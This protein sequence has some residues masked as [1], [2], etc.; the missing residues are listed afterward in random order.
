MAINQEFVDVI[1]QYF[2]V[3]YIKKTQSLVKRGKTHKE[4]LDIHNEIKII[5][6]NDSTFPLWSE[7][8]AGHSQRE[9]LDPTTNPLK[10]FKDNKT[11]KPKKEG[12][13]NCKF[14]KWLRNLT[15]ADH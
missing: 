8:I 5:T 12:A 2:S 9:L 7:V 14:F 3:I 6:F 1:K 4:V 13:F 15:K 11:W 10:K